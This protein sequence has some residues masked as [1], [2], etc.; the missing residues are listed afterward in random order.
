M[1]GTRENCGIWAGGTEWVSHTL[2]GNSVTV[3]NAPRSA[4]ACL[5]F[6]R[7]L[8]CS[9]GESSFSF[10]TRELCAFSVWGLMAQLLLGIAPGEEKSRL[11]L[12]HVASVPI[13]KLNWLLLIQLVVQEM[14]RS[15]EW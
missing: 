10:S 4:P 12:H 15:H 3:V 5:G 8:Y 6:A 2:E 7:H 14:C 9:T 1:N 11:F 13:W